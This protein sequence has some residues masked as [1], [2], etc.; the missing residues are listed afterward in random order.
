MTRRNMA[1]TQTGYPSLSR[2]GGGSMERVEVPRHGYGVTP[3]DGAALEG[4]A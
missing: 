2:S 1:L 4:A 3:I